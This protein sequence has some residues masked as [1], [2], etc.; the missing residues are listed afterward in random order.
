MCKE[1]QWKVIMIKQI[2]NTFLFLFEIIFD[3]IFSL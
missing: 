1:I 2:K 3:L